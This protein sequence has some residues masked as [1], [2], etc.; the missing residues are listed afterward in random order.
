MHLGPKISG[1]EL[2]FLS[3]WKSGYSLHYTIRCTGA[4]KIIYQHAALL[5]FA[6]QVYDNFVCWHTPEELLLHFCV[7]SIWNTQ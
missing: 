7:S 3:A 1:V 5:I 4:K 2:V 6:P